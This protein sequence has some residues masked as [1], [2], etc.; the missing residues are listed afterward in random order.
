MAKVFKWA[1]ILFGL[2]AGGLG[3]RTAFLVVRDSVD[4][5]YNDLARQ[6]RWAAAT[7]IAAAAAAVSQALERLLT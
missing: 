3:V 7:A 2:S 6:G 1:S 4:D 5:L